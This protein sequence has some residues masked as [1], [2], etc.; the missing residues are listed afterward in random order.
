MTFYAGVTRIKDHLRGDSNNVRAC[1]DVRPE[2]HTSLLAEKLRK[3]AAGSRK[4]LLDEVDKNTCGSAEECLPKAPRISSSDQPTLP[5]LFD[6]NA[7]AD[8]DAAV[9]RFA[10]AT[11]TPFNVL[12]DTS[13]KEMLFTVGSYGPAYRPPNIN[14]LREGLLDAEYS[15]IKR[16]VT[17]AFFSKL[18]QDGCTVCSDGWSDVHRR[19]L[20]N[21]TAANNKGSTFLQKFDTKGEQKVGSRLAPSSLLL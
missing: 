7:K 11:G 18:A 17:D 2:L 12:T 19:P 5:A 20:L 1:P 4:R 13:F 6:K 14:Q 3:E 8:C 16:D 21:A 10:Y 15:A 9:A